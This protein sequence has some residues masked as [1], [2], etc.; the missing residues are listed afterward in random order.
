MLA[1]LQGQVEQAHELLNQAENLG[2]TGQG[3][4]HSE[5][6]QHWRFYLALKAD[7][8]LTH[9]QIHKATTRPNSWQ[10]RLDLTALQYELFVQQEQFE[11]AMVAANQ[12]ERLGRNAGLDVAPARSAFLLAKLG[13][14]SEATAAV[15]ESLTRLP[16]IDPAQFPHYYLAQTLWELDR[17]EAAVHAYQAYQQAWCDGSPYCRHWDLRDARDLLQT[18][19]KP[20]PQMPTTDPATV[21]VPLED[22]IRAFIAAL[23]T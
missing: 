16:R 14:T 19:S 9:A 5:H 3:L 6:I 20:V 12:Q 8:T 22:E 21:T 18:I 2:P 1:A 11:Q 4:W 15:E 10:H 23:E 7:R 13:R 17:P